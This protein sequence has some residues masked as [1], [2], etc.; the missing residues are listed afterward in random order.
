MSICNSLEENL[1]Q[2]EKV[3][4]RFAG[5]LVNRITK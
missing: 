2:K 4:E 1:T 5:A 3:A